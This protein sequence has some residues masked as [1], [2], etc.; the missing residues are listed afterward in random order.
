MV[1]LGLIGDGQDLV[2]VGVDDGIKCSQI[3]VIQRKVQQTLPECRNQIQGKW[4]SRPET[5]TQNFSKV[6]KKLFINECDRSRPHCKSALEAAFAHVG[7]Q[8]G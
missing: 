1:E 4:N 5:H 8:Q 7:H 2:D 3:F 6:L